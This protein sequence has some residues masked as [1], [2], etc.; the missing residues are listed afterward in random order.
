MHSLTPFPFEE[1]RRVPLRHSH[2]AYPPAEPEEGGPESSSSGS[3]ADIESRHRARAWAFQEK[4]ERQLPFVHCVDMVLPCPSARALAE[5]LG[6]VC[7]PRTWAVRVALHELLS[8]EMLQVLNDPSADLRLVSRDARCDRTNSFALLHRCSPSRTSP[9]AP[10]RL[11][12]SL[13]ASSY[14]TL[15]LPGRPLRPRTSPRPPLRYAVSVDLSPASFRRKTRSRILWA[16]TNRVEPQ[17]CLAAA[18]SSSDVPWPS[19]AAVRPLEPRW[20]LL[21]PSRNPPPPL[22]GPDGSGALSFYEWLG[23]A[24]CGFDPSLVLPLFPAAE[25]EEPLQQEQQVSL[26]ILRGRGLFS[27]RSL[28]ALLPFL[29]DSADQLGWAAVHLS[30][31][32]DTPVAMPDRTVIFTHAHGVHVLASDPP[33]ST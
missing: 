28:A 3:E 20:A 13:D 9:G 11:L 29:S 2:L 8:A 22:P 14:A 30:P 4:M 16:L 7:A 31:F 18:A 26:C 23:M 33:T 19:S 15:G 12:L 21:P 32:S 24:R 10:P 17:E 6:A 1:C 5:R 25:H 27:P